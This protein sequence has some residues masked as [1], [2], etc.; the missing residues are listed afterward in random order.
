ME[1]LRRLEALNAK[2]AEA[3]LRTAAVDVALHIGEVLYGN[4]GATD[5]L[6]F[7]VIGDLRPSTTHELAG[8]FSIGQKDP[9]QRGPAATTTRSRMTKMRHLAPRSFRTSFSG[10]NGENAGKTSMTLMASV[11]DLIGETPLIEITR[12]DRG[13]YV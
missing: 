5:R 6:D 7:T 11:L 8:H 12:F 9:G 2:R 10:G 13:P 4:V 1:T 3:S